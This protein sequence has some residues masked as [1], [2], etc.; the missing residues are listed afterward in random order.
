MTKAISFPHPDDRPY[1]GESGKIEALPHLIVTPGTLRAQWIA[2][3][4]TLFRPKSIDIF[5]YESPKSG[6]EEFWSATGPFHSSKQKPQNKIVVMS[7]SV[8]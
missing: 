1:V 2:E 8:R 5:Q 3:L 7:H 4:K 6:N